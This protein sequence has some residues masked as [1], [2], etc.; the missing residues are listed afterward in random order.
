MTKKY[1][2][3]IARSFGKETSEEFTEA[4]QDTHK[5]GSTGTSTGGGG[6]GSVVDE[7]DWFNPLGKKGW[8]F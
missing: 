2:G 7:P 6:S 4:V 1:S 5:T 3:I 8:R